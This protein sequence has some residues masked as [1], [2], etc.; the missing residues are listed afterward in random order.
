MDV[1]PLYAIEIS[2][3]R[4][5]RVYAL[6]QLAALGF[7]M[8]DLQRPAD[9]LRVDEI[10]AYHTG[11]RGVPVF[12][13]DL[14]I[15]Q[16]GG[17]LYVVDGQHRLLAMLRLAAEYPEAPAALDVIDG[18]TMP[19]RELFTL[20]NRATPV[21]DYVVNGTLNAARRRV[22]D[23]FGD[24]FR[25]AF[26]RFISPA[27]TPRRPNVS[28]DRLLDR[29]AASELLLTR[30]DSGDHLFEYVAW[31]SARLEPLDAANA[32]RA[33]DKNAHPPLFLTSDPDET[34]AND[35]PLVEEFLLHAP[36]PPPPRPVPPRSARLAPP[37]RRPLPMS[38]RNAVWNAAFGGPDVGAGPCHSCGRVVS[39]QDF[40]CGHVV[41]ASRG[42]VDAVG[43]L[44]VVCRSCN[45]GMGSRDMHEF[46]ASLLVGTSSLIDDVDPPW[47]LARFP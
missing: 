45:R 32:R 13:G 17:R 14:V 42:G 37:A 25:T 11:K 34:W 43:N 18:S 46:S 36:T 21:P 1:T 9:M 44:R 28:L 20:V 15:S 31:V 3:G 23:A 22:L 35:A 40:E 5:K 47:R 19:M 24:R 39:H 41:A 38:L 30:F 12:A 8:P 7:E 33:K 16:H 26:P 29:L 10:V 4:Q 27:R 2:P 6:R